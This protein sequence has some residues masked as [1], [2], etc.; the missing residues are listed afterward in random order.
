[1]RINFSK[2]VFAVIL[3]LYLTGCKSQVISDLIKPIKVKP[4]IKDTVLLSD[5][6]YSKDYDI[7]LFDNN[8][9]NTQFNKNDNEL[10]IEPTENMHGST[11]LQFVLDDQIYSI[12]IF[13]EDV[14][15]TI[16]YKFKYKPGKKVKQVSVAGSFNNWNRS[17][18]PLTDPDG[19]GVYET[20]IPLEPGNYTYKLN[21]DGKDILDPSNSETEPT[22]FD[23]FNSVLK[24]RENSKATDYLYILSKNTNGDKTTIDFLYDNR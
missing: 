2:Y 20:E 15:K 13:L 10:I 14:N 19:D 12:P 8:Q 11:I 24:I 22:G 7:T 18:N 5:I 21:V 1:M 4:G 23:G 17:S 9:L 3:F 16:I 6:F